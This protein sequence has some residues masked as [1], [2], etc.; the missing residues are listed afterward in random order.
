MT[1][2]CSQPDHD[3]IAPLRFDILW[4]YYPLIGL[5]VGQTHFLFPKLKNLYQ[6]RQSEQKARLF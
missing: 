5:S 1:K 4:T 2:R 6:I 3:L